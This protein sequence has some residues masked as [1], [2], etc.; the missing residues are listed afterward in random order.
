MIKFYIIGPENKGEGLYTLVTEKGEGLAS[1]F[2]SSSG[3]AIGDLEADRPER[4]KE[5][6]KKFGKYKVLYLG[7]DNMT[8]EKLSKLNKRFHSN[9]SAPTQKKSKLL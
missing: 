7:D 5:W 2:C 8:D 1:H 3:F 6:K 4:Q 9:K